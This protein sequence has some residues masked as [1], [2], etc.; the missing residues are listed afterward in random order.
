MNNIQEI[1]VLIANYN[2]A[3][4]LRGALQSVYAQTY[5]YWRVAICDDGSIDDS[6]K[7]YKE[8][9]SDSRISVMHNSHNMG[10]AFTRKRLIEETDGEL[11]CFLD[12]DD[13]LTPNAL[14]DHVRVHMEHSDVSIV[15]SRRYLCDNALNIQAESRVL[16][17]PEGKSY[18]TLKDFREEHLV[19]FKKS[20]YNKTAGMNPLYRLAED[21]YMN[22]MMEEVGK[23]YCLDK[24]CYKYRRNG[25][26]LTRDYGR[27]MFWNMLVQYDTCKRRGIDVEEQVYS[28][29]ED[30]LRFAEKEEIYKAECRVRQSAAY[31]FGAAL[32]KPIKFI[33]NL[34]TKR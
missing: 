15:F 3:K 4:Y 33:Q 8:Y 24:I 16:V 21:T 22:V 2:N 27:H 9:A 34:V 26:S 14:E 31:R 18:F 11:M 29:F 5:P 20:Y 13:E 30:T 32:L 10:V 23:V 28:W 1:T 25:N 6:E 17:I 12:P 7:V 19:S